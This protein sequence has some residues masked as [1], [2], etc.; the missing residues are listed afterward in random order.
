ML[1][2]S[3]DGVP[4]QSAWREV[5]AAGRRIGDVGVE[6]DGDAV[7]RASKRRVQTVPLS[8]SLTFLRALLGRHSARVGVVVAAGGDAA[9]EVQKRHR[10]SGWE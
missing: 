10:A 4:E 8:R 2:S 3:E 7:P 1:I 6:Q 9:G 5:V